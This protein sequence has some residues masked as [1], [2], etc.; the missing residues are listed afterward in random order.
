M[1]HD[2]VVPRRR[3]AARAARGAGEVHVLHEL[4]ADVLAQYDRPVG[5]GHVIT[6][7]TTRPVDIPGVAAQ[8]RRAFR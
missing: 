7:D 3:Y 5:N 8:I 2:R 1:R 4:P 6:V